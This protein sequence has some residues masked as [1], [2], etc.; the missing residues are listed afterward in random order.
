MS[1]R[2]IPCI[3]AATGFGYQVKYQVGVSASSRWFKSQESATNWLIAQLTADRN[4]RLYLV[5]VRYKPMKAWETY[6]EDTREEIQ[7]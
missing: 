3:M 7:L 6:T 1:P 2:K 5:S 4:Y